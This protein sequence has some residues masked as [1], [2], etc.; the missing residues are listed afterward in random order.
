MKKKNF[1]SF[2]IIGV[3][4]VAFILVMVPISGGRQLQGKDFIEK[5]SITQDAVLVD[6]RTPNEFN[7]SHINKAI[8]IDFENQSFISEIK[9]LDTFKTYFIYCRS[10]NRSGQVIAIM[11]NNGFKNIYE[12][13]GG[14]STYP[15][16]LQ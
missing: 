6:V 16:L 8:N 3:V 10:G 14:I 1:L 12:L 9:K 7:T 15:E 13:R 5:Y 11:K 4:L 2:G